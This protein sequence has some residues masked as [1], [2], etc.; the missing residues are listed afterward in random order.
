VRVG[1][2]DDLV[3]TDDGVDGAGLVVVPWLLLVV[4]L[5]AEGVADA[6]RGD[7]VGVGVEPGVADDAPADV[8]GSAEL[9][10]AG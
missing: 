5:L 3:G 9:G 7:G 4:C 2:A 10:A 1:G 6:D 8:A